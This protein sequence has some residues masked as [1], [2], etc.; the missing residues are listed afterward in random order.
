MKSRF[1]VVDC[2]GYKIVCSDEN[3]CDKILGARPYMKE[4][5]EIEKKALISPSFICTNLKPSKNREVYYMFHNYKNNKYIKVVVKFN[6]EKFGNVISAF[7]TD[8]G[9]EGE[10]IIWTPS[11]N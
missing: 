6:K 4:W 5:E 11:N 10:T 1:E 3:W 9:K 2:R 8:G 7:P